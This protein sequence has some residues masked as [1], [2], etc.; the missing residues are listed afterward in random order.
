M[1]LKRYCNIP[2]YAQVCIYFTVLLENIHVVY[3]ICEK[4]TRN[5]FELRTDYKADAKFHCK[6]PPLRE[7][8]L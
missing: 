1:A 8:C 6:M 3:S 2:I 5:S 4:I 7:A